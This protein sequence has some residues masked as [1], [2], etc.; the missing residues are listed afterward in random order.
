M[1]NQLI[2]MVIK[3]DPHGERA[4]DI[5]SRL[6]EERVVFLGDAISDPLAN[7]IIAQLL[8]L[9]HE[10][11]DRDIY[12]YINS[13]G[14]NVHSTMAIYD[15]MK[16]IKPDVS[17]ICVGLAASGAAVLLG[18]GVKG[19]RFSLP[20]S[21]IMIHQP[22]SE[23]GGQATDIQIHAEEIIRMKK[24]LNQIL[25]EDCGQKLEKIEHDTERDY[26]MTASQ[27]VEYGIIDNVIKSKKGT[28]ESQTKK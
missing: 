24:R 6:L 16:Y 21:K 27:A 2:P 11:P 28:I 12:M 15:T 19:K 3:R 10:N 1:K 26:F 14:G 13:P 8:H 4:F 25:A 7:T 18:G 22:L 17:T 9:D 5:Y 20:N 23:I